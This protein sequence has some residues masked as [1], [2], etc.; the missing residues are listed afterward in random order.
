MLS[1]N[2]VLEN[3]NFCAKLEIE[4]IFYFILTH[5]RCLLDSSILNLH[6]ICFFSS[7]IPEIKSSVHYNDRLLVPDSPWIGIGQPQKR[8]RPF[9]TL[10]E[11]IEAKRKRSSASSIP[12][13][14]VRLDFVGHFPQWSEKQARCKLPNCKSKTYVKC[15][16]CKIDLCFNKDRNCFQKFHV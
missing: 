7:F 16:K 6:L 9:C 12:P 8:K 15:V 14:D 10:D 13:K 1:C 2:Y 11:A 3:C 4:V 5:K